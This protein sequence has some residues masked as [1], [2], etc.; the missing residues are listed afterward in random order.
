MNWTPLTEEDEKNAW[1][2]IYETLLFTPHAVEKV[3]FPK[4]SSVRY[5]IS[6][7]YNEGFKEDYYDDLH[8]KAIDAFKEIT[9]NNLI[10]ALNF[11]HQSYSFN[12][13][14]PFEKDEFGEWL[15]PFFPNGDYVFFLTADLKSGA[16]CDGIN[17]EIF[18]LGE[19][20]I[21]AFE[22]N[23]PLIFTID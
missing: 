8:S 5:N 11:Q 17:G 2:F 19:K 18:L 12:P 7:Y 3:V 4:L 10:F 16:F 15:I 13:Q 9:A 23:R 20:I 21:A 22:K 14:L 1:R 6:K